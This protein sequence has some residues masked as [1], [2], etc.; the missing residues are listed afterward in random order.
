MDARRWAMVME[1]QAC[2]EDPVPKCG[3]YSVTHSPSANASPMGPESAMAQGFRHRPRISRPRDRRPKHAP[4]AAAHIE[5]PQRSPLDPSTHS[6]HISH[7][8]PSSQWLPSSSRRSAALVLATSVSDFGAT[9]MLHAHLSRLQAALHARSLLSSAPIS[10]SPLLTLTRRVL[11]RGTARTSSSPSTSLVSRRSSVRP[12]A[13]TSSSP[14]MS[15]RASRRPISS[16]S[17]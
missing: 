4:T 8:L 13:A 16:S 9:R 15:T 6:P 7:I 2:A 17:R 3:G 11:T 14:P 10:P 1:C 5:K 12:E